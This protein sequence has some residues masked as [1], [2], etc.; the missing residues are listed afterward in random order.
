MKT[1]SFILFYLLFFASS[2]YAQDIKLFEISDSDEKTVFISLSDI[3]PVSEHA[4]SLAIPEDKRNSEHLILSQ[5]YRKRFLAKTKIAETDKVFLYDYAKNKLVSL[6]VKNLD[7][8]ANLSPYE[9]EGETPHSQYDYMIGFQIDKKSAKDFGN[10]SNE[11]LIYVGKENPFA[12]KQ[13]TAIIWKKISSKE[14][15]SKKIKDEFGVLKQ[16]YN[17]GDCYSF[18]YENLEYFIQDFLRD[19]SIFARR[20]LVLDSKTKAIIYEELFSEGE[21][22]SLAPLNFINKEDANNMNQWTGKLFKNKENVI[23][24]FEYHS[25]G[26]PYI[27]VL[28]KK[29]TQIKIYCDNRH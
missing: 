25:F 23:F 11:I 6:S 19:K 29:P 9:T 2:I 15:P 1:F 16:K 4:D 14:F 28:S 8:V 5:K 26:F 12:E 20:L 27:T 17:T 21:S 24:G 7:V 10:L 3:Y 13:L 22:D 18:K